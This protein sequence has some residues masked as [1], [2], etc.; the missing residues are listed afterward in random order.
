MSSSFLD[1]ILAAKRAELAELRDTYA[2]V[3]TGSQRQMALERMAPTRDFA[4]ALR[5]GPL[6]RIIAEFKRAS[7]S[8]GTIR[9]HADVQDIVRGYAR[10]GAA[11]ISVLTDRHFDGSL[12]DLRAARQVVDIPLLCKDFILEHA[13]I[14]AAREAGADAILLIVAALPPP[15]LKQLI[16]YAQEL[17]LA[18]LCE[19]HDAHEIDRAMAAGATIVGVNARDLRTFEVDLDAALALRSLVPKTFTFVLESGV[20]SFADMDKVRQVGVDAALVGTSLMASDDPAEALEALIR[21][22]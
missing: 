8:Q 4:R 1:T 18:V 10:A 19:A 5:Y 3:L 9:E 21:S 7:P 16:T 6:P 22:C 12:D 13:Q 15:T 14:F 20:H 2:G 17:E 11:A